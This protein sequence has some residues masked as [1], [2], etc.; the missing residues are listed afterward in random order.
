MGLLHDGRLKRLF[1]RTPILHSAGLHHLCW[2]G[3]AGVMWW[4]MWA[5]K[6]QIPAFT[7]ALQ[8]LRLPNRY[9]SGFIQIVFHQWEESLF[10]TWTWS[11][12]AFLPQSPPQRFYLWRI[13]KKREL[14]GASCS[15]TRSPWRS[16]TEDFLPSAVIW[17]VTSPRG[18]NTNRTVLGVQ[19]TDHLALCSLFQAHAKRNMG[20]QWLLLQH[21]RLPRESGH[22][23]H[24]SGQRAA[25][26][27]GKVM[28]A[29][30]PRAS[31]NAFLNVVCVHLWMDKPTIE[32]V[33]WGAVTGH[34]CLSLHANSRV[35]SCVAGLFVKTS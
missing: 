34:W 25:V 23:N 8:S 19:H 18:T 30:W 4:R 11:L 31:Q 14:W 22:D 16:S 13:T 33:K 10:I 7:D 17:S 26:G 32:L 1:T 20:T 2:R 15:R 24:H 6:Q 28:A 12:C 27:Q 3:A 35:I 21:G 9:S 29:V 5:I